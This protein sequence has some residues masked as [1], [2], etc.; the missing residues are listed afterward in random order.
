MAN[1]IKFGET[2]VTI[3]VLTDDFTFPFRAAWRSVALMNPT[4]NDKITL[5]QPVNNKPS[6]TLKSLAGESIEKRFHVK[7]PTALMLD[8]SESTITAGT[9][10]LIE[11]EDQGTNI[12]VE[13]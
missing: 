2:W 9:V 11:Y 10:V 13:Q 6:I 3:T 8:A 1:T 4:A 7:K 12:F 5:I